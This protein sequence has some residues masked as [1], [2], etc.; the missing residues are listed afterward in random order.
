ML[1]SKYRNQ[2]AL[3]LVGGWRLNTDRPDPHIARG[4]WMRSTATMTNFCTE[5][6]SVDQPKQ[7]F[8]VALKTTS[9]I[10]FTSLSRNQV[11]TLDV[12]KICKKS[13]K[14]GTFLFPCSTKWLVLSSEIRPMQRVTSEQLNKQNW[15]NLNLGKIKYV[16][17]N[18]FIVVPHRC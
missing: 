8:T 5:D 17:V 15:K 12:R 7:N 18:L 9:V 4:I 14:L 11:S 2:F 13:L 6:G 3:A 16:S 1:I 10:F